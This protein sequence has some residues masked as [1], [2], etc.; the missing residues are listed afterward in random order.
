MSQIASMHS[1][2]VHEDA[3]WVCNEDTCVGVIFTVLLSLVLTW[4]IPVGCMGTALE[5]RSLV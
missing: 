1:V 3:E 2:L 4:S 5:L